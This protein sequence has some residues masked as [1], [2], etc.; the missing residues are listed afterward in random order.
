[1]K[2]AKY[3]GLGNDYIVV[4]PK[5]VEGELT[6]ESVAKICRRRW[7]V[8]SD[9][10]LLGPSPSETCDVRLTIYNSDGSSAE[11][12]GNGLRIFARYLWDEKLIDRETFTVETDGGPVTCRLRDQG[13]VITVDLGHVSFQS[14]DI[15]IVGPDRE[16]LRETLELDGEQWT[17]CCASLGNPHCVVLCSDDPTPELARRLG[18]QIESDPRFPEKTNVQFLQV[19]DRRNIRIEIWE[20]GSGYTLASGS[21]STA[22]SAVAVKLGLCERELTAHMPG[23][24][25]QLHFTP[26]FFATL[27]GPVA[28]VG[29]GT[30]GPDVF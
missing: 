6:R 17:F 11:K 22:S 24:K 12:S 30:V 13:E 25:L 3:H 28:Y 19:I 1:M 2:Y 15:P 8:G 27:T 10:I 9:G 23:G 29:R 4:H 26:D 7:G 20:R 16:V 5:D 18:P 14:R 21:S